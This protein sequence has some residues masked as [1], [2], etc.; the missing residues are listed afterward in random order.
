M[1]P[2]KPPRTGVEEDVIDPQVAVNQPGGVAQIEG[3]A[4]HRAEQLAERLPL[5]AHQQGE[6]GVFHLPRKGQPVLAGSGRVRGAD[7]RRLHL[8]L[9]NGV[10]LPQKGQQFGQSRPPRPPGQPEQPRPGQWLAGQE[11]VSREVLFQHLEP[12]DGQGHVAPGQLQH[13]GFLPQQGRSPVVFGKTADEIAT[14]DDHV[15]DEAILIELQFAQGQRGKTGPNP[16]EIRLR[17]SQCR[18]DVPSIHR[19]KAPPDGKGR[20]D[21]DGRL[22]ESRGKTP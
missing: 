18:H 4:P 10:K 8:V 12:G 20:V 19:S 1:T 21:K 11:R 15:V 3:A 14:D 22:N 13:P 6:Q 9:G 17:Q 7:P 16:V 5:V 2:E